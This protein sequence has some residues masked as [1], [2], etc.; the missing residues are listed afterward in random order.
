MTFGWDDQ[1]S[2]PQFAADIEWNFVKF[3]I[4]RE[5]EVVGRFAS[6]FDRNAL[7]EAIELLL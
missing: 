3:L 4:N 2:G 6:P 1:N 7:E 5:G